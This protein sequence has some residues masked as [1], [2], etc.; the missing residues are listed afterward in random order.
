MIR[1]PFIA[2]GHEPVA[3]IILGME[4]G[5][6]QWPSCKHALSVVLQGVAGSALP[7]QRAELHNAQ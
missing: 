5:R 2:V 4:L 6:A 3:R 7:I 1:K